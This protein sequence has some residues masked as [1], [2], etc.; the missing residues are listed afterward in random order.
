[1][2]EIQNQTSN[3]EP[4]I[5][6]TPIKKTLSVKQGS[7]MAKL[8]EMLEMPDGTTIKQISKELKWQKHTARGA[9]SRLKTSYGILVVNDKIKDGDRTYRVSV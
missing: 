1:M 4:E 2:S 5:V 6:A 9:L 8:I 3:Q 7:K